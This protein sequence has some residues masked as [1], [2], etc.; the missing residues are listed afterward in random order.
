MLEGMKRCYESN[1]L[2]NPVQSC[3]Y[4]IEGFRRLAVQAHH[5]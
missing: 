2:A 5:W 4:Y 3:S 1:S